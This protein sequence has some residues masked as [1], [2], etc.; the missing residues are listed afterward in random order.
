MLPQVRDSFGA[1]PFEA[2]PDNSPVPSIAAERQGESGFE[3]GTGPGGEATSA[4]E[5]RRRCRLNGTRQSKMEILEYFG[6]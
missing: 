3:P 4:V 2:H 1:I 6:K 5:G